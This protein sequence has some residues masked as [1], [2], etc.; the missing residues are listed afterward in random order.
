MD[1]NEQIEEEET[2]VSEAVENE[3]EVEADTELQ[4]E[5]TVEEELVISIEGEEPIAE[6]TASAPDWVR[7]LRK[8]NRE[9]QKRI[10]ELEEQVRANQP[11]ATVQAPGAKPKLEDFD[12]DAEV[13]ESKLT[14]WFERKRKADEA[15]AKAEDEAKKANQ[16][17]QAKLEGYGTHKAAL[18]VPDYEDAESAVQETLSVTQQGI[19]LKGA[20]NPARLV[21][22]L[23]KNPV[24]AKKL[25][26]ITDPVEFAWAAAKLETKVT[27]VTK[28][29]KAPA[30][31]K[32]VTGTARISGAVDSNLERL[33]AEAEKTG[34]Y[35][36]VAQYKRQKAR[37]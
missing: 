35:S 29:N 16:A 25:A 6:D 15:A 9:D 13:Y 22:A 26:A 3:Q 12:Y 19:I 30:P 31:E 4:S 5:D 8:K 20:E 10:R 14:E 34:D 2:I 27:M 36:K 11:A 21:Y 37:K 24:A 33:R 7:E 18:K 1:V 23:G 32:T 17:W 28:T